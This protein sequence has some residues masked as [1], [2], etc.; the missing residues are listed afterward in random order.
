MSEG[1]LA[2]IFISH[3]SGDATIA[4]T[5]A[6]RLDRSLTF[7]DIRSMQPGENNLSEMK[8][9]LTRTA[10]FVFVVS[11]QTPRECFAFFE[12]TEAEY[13]KTRQSEMEILVWPINGASHKDCP[14]WMQ[15][16]FSVPPSYT[17]AD[18]SREIRNLTNKYFSK[19]RMLSEPIYEGHE[20]VERKISVDYISH[21]ATTQ[22]PINAIILSGLQGIGRR[23]LARKLPARLFPA[24]RDVV[25]EFEL[26]DAAD[27][28]DLYI[29][30]L[31]D[32]E[33]A[34]D[35]KKLDAIQKSFPRA[36][37]E[38]AKFIA[39]CL[40]HWGDINQAIIIEIRWGLRD[41]GTELRTWFKL[42]LNEL[43]ATPTVRVIFISGRKL[44]PES[45]ASFKNVLHYEVPELDAETIG[46]ILTK[47]VDRKLYNPTLFARLANL[48]VGHPDT[49]HH[50]AYLVNN[51]R[52]PAT[53]LEKP[54]LIFAFQ[55]RV[56]ED[57]YKQGTLNELEQQ[58][59]SVLCW[60]PGL[61]TN[62]LY[63]IFPNAPRGQI[64]EMLWKLSDYCLVEQTQN[65]SYHLPTVV[66]AT[67][68]RRIPP[69]PD[70]LQNSII[71]S[72][73]KLVTSSDILPEQIEPL[74]LAFTVHGTELPDFIK[75][76]ITPGV[77]AEVVL[78]HYE[79]GRSA[80]ASEEITR[81]FSIVAKLAEFAL[82][83][84]VPND[85]LE[86]ILWTGAD[87]MARLGR[88]PETITSQMLH[89]GFGS[90]YYAQAS[91]KFHA[92]RDYTGAIADLQKALATRSFRR[93]TIR[94]LVRL[95]LRVGNA[96]RA[97]DVL[98]TL[99]NTELL[100]DSG[101][102]SMRIRA[103]RMQRRHSEAEELERSLKALDDDYGESLIFEATKALRAEKY[104]D[105]RKF[106]DL[107][108]R[109][110]RANQPTLKFL[111]CVIDLNEGNAASLPEACGL[112][113]AIGRVDDAHQLRA[114]AALLVDKD[115]RRAETEIQRVEHRTWMDWNLE[116][117]ILTQKAL[118]PA[119]QRDAALMNE[120]EQR[121]TEV[122]ARSVSALDINI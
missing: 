13:Q 4:R 58:I 110:P 2:L 18:T 101:F 24:M 57:I 90:A 121:R 93:R 31:S 99:S 46:Y 51:G 63:E 49:A 60:F 33:G 10:V 40:S 32:I 69:I 11:P 72:L 43:I 114:R 23:T 111:R 115:W 89:R 6:D 85:T 39:K 1:A 92:R 36:P 108:M 96:P 74:I 107:A 70:P 79:K 97:L 116:L 88:D 106:V 119:V 68:M 22:T 15:R 104:P 91:Y 95:Y 113:E 87:A 26:P 50:I 55:D 34:L 56:L 67:F 82:T 54:S 117:Q 102:L 76:A 81:S 86:N 105:A 25:P 5:L 118:D 9:A 37:K 62:L 44:A 45:L 71:N 30:L 35:L 64:S 122:L 8:T 94:L 52:S 59:L 12:A 21:L 14:E 17:V 41:N 84:D 109:K 103:L 75:A 66:R 77:L 83:L 28:I 29:H 20:N 48:A 65:G 78:R 42:L 61:D 47:L 38:Q 100:R 98:D 120:V 7:V 53:I 112:A 27:A 16:Y 3:W 73:D 19:R 80:A